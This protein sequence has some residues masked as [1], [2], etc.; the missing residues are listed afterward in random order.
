MNRESRTRLLPTV[1]LLLMLLAALVQLS[2]NSDGVLAPAT[3]LFSVMAIP[4]EIVIDETAGE[5]SGTS[6][7]I[8]RVLNA[9]GFPLKDIKVTFSTTAGTMASAGAPGQPPTEILTDSDGVALDI[10]TM[11][12][13]DPASAAVTA[14]SA[15]LAQQVTVSRTVFESTDPFAIIG[16]S[17]VSPVGRGTPIIFDGRDSGDDDGDT[18]TCFQW[19]IDSTINAND[20]IVQGVSTFSRSYSMDQNLSVILRVSDDPAATAVCPP[21]SAPADPALFSPVIDAIAYQIVC[22]PTGPTADAGTTQIIT[23]SGGTASVVLDGGNSSDLDSGIVSYSWNC[24]NGDPT[25]GT[26]TAT[27]IYDTALTFTATLTVTNGCGQTDTDTVRI[28]VRNP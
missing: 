24:G 18:I 27:C 10:L 1:G 21:N 22:D 13:T 17:P 26:Q 20:E 19:E 2:C 9:N 28:T 16:V 6:K 12:S 25:I 14:S 3:S 8:V 5:T 23:L 7:I 4:P 11:T 15:T